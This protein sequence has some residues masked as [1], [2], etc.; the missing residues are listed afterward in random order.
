[1]RADNSS[2][3]LLATLTAISIFSARRRRDNRAPEE[4]LSPL[5]SSCHDN[6]IPDNEIAVAALHCAYSTYCIFRSDYIPLM[7]LTQKRST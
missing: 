6:R 3:R 2:V 4:T 7:Y 1:M 5:I